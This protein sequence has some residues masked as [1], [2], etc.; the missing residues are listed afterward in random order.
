MLPDIL[1]LEGQKYVKEQGVVLPEGMT[2]KRILH[3]DE[4]NDGKVRIGMPEVLPL[5]IVEYTDLTPARQWFWF[6]Q[7]IHGFTGYE[8]W[9]EKKLSAFDLESLKRE[10]R[11]ITHER[12]AFTNNLGTDN[13]KD[14]ISGKNLNLSCIPKQGAIYTA[15][16]IV[17]VLGPATNRGVPIETLDGR[18][19][20]PPIEKVNRLLTPW[21][22][23]CATNVAANKPRPHPDTWTPIFTPSGRY[24]IDPFPN[25]TDIPTH[26]GRDVLVPIFSNGNKTEETYTRDGV[27]YAVNWIP[28]R[29]LSDRVYTLPN[30]YV[31]T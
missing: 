15:G 7:I 20:P 6:R 29:R 19:P 17:R 31:Q 23:F 21:L 18:K 11:S 24:R 12:K 13:C 26:K 8:H 3:D 5:W 4:A 2:F 9:D 1:Y 10:W 27:S 28:E 14:Y 30:P 16:N 25:M 22:V